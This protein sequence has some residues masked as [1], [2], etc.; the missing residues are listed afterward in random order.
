V[1]EEPGGRA[2]QEFAAGGGFLVVMGLGSGQPWDLLLIRAV[3]ALLDN[4]AA[5]GAE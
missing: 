5:P 2:A 4:G 3:D 1:L